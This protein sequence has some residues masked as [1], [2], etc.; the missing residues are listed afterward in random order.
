[1]NQWNE[2]PPYGSTGFE[3]GAKA[4]NVSFGIYGNIDQLPEALKTWC[5][6]DVLITYYFLE[7][8]ILKK[9]QIATT[10]LGISGSTALSIVCYR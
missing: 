5:C 8:K 1:M 4:V 3:S 2:T 10:N 9:R 7:Q 6:F